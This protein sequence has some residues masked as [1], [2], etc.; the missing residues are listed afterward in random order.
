MVKIYILLPVHNRKE[1]T[2]KFIDCLK[3][4]SYQNYHLILI[5]DGSTDE[6]VEMVQEAIPTS[7]IING[8]GNWWWG[9]SLHQGYNWLK[10]FN[11][12][13]NDF[14]L[15]INNDVTFESDFLEKAINYLNRKADTLLLAQCFSEQTNLLL[16]SGVHW[17]L[18]ERTFKNA[19]NPEKINCLPTRGLFFRVK[20]FWK[21]GGFHP[22]LLPHYLSDYEFTIR[23]YHKGFHLVT[24]YSIKIWTDERQTGLINLEYK[25]YFKYLRYYFSKKAYGNPIYYST[26]V[27]LACPKLFDKF[28]YLVVIWLR[29]LR[30]LFYCPFTNF[31][32]CRIVV[33]IFRTLKTIINVSRLFINPNRFKSL[34]AL[35][36]GEYL[37]GNG[38][39][40]SF[41]LKSRMNSLGEPIPDFTYPFLDFIHD[42][43]KEIAIL[44]FYGGDS[45]LFFAKK[46]AKVITIEKKEQFEKIF[47]KVIPPNAEVS[48]IK[49]D[50]EFDL[51]YINNYSEKFDMIIYHK[52]HQI[53]FNSEICKLLNTN[54]VLVINNPTQLRKK[55]LDW[56]SKNFKKLEF[57]G[58][59]PGQTRKDCTTVFYRVN[60]CLDI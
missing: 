18:K 28:V 36:Y 33:L 42:R 9:G 52:L 43:L 1:I 40:K 58:I 13:E 39:F 54:G 6:T 53:Y 30:D 16:D 12:P 31:I 41:M 35:Y 10:R 34:Y 45:V 37:Q 3:K 7:T 51:K 19:D 27:L 22:F 47:K 2:R 38:W 32:L 23:A 17:N 24:D 5:N 49:Q 55:D 48:W 59:T 4:Q 60:N 44:E 21:I 25:P 15:I 46:A 50:G 11:P 26:F 8:N 56:L 20:D 57:W 29:V 14:V